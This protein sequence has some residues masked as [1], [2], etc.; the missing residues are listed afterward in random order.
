MK[1][2]RVSTAG[3]TATRRRGRAAGSKAGGFSEALSDAAEAPTSAAVSGAAALGPVDALLTLQEVSDDPEGHGQG[4][5]RGEELLERLDE[6]R[7]ALLA[8]R[9]PLATLE[10]LAA[11]VAA[12]RGEVDDPGLAHILDE[13]EVRAAVELAKLSR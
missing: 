5:R 9:L 8:G 6:L 12:K 3:T 11:T 10:R 13:I 7:L 1:I 4:R 2:D